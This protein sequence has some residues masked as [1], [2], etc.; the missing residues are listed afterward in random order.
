MPFGSWQF[1]IVLVLI[2]IAVFFMI[3]LLTMKIFNREK[4][5]RTIGF[6]EIFAFMVIPFLLLDYIGYEA[7]LVLIFLP[8]IW[9][10]VFLV[11]M[12]GRLMPAI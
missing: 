1:F 12:Y 4:I 3:R 9:L 7:T 6:H 11:I 10:G 5:M 2:V 8:V